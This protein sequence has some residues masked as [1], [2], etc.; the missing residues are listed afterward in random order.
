MRQLLQLIATLILAGVVTGCS[1]PDPLGFV[2][3][4]DRDAR[5]SSYETAAEV[6]IARINADR[7]RADRERNG[8]LFGGMILAFVI[9]GLA[10]IRADE[11]VRLAQAAAQR[12]P[13][14]VVHV[15]PAAEWPDDPDD[16]PDMVEP[17]AQVVPPR[18][19]SQR[20]SLPPPVRRG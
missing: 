2:A 13:A 8:L 11:R 4:A 19:I 5:I 18:S 3:R 9:V 17:S 20:R 1:S 12:L 7:Q 15:L 14:P 10:A 16:W 6:E